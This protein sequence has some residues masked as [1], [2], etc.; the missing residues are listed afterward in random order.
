[1]AVKDNQH[2]L[3]YSTSGKTVHNT[4]EEERTQGMHQSSYNEINKHCS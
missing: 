1:M 2:I 4:S 3:Y